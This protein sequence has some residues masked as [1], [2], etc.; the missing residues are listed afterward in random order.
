MNEFEKE[1][2]S[3]YINGRTIESIVIKLY[4]LKKVQNKSITKN[5]CKKEVETVVTGYIIQSCNNK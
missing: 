1:I 2:L 4:G 3:D 5:E